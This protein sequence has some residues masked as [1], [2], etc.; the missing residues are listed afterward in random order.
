MR[1][2]ASDEDVYGI[3]D[4]RERYLAGMVVSAMV[5]GSLLAVFIMLFRKWDIL[6]FAGVA[7]LGSCFLLIRAVQCGWRIMEMKQCY[8]E[9]TSECFVVR[10]AEKNGRY[11][12]CRI[13]LDEIEKIIEGSRRGVPEFYVVIYMD[14]TKSFV[15]YDRTRI[16]KNIILVRSFGYTKDAFHDFYRK[17]LWAV[18]GRTRIIGTNTQETWYLK[19]PQAGFLLCLGTGAVY[20][21]LKAAMYLI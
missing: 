11:E 17:L 20:L 16:R 10:Q 7:F 19:K 9:I 6:Y 21:L 4:I 2:Q 12:S 18:T 13:Y 1:L 14:A 5:C 3:M 15:L 8:L